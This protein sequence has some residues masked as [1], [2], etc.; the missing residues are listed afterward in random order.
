MQAPPTVAYVDDPP[1][2][3]GVLKK[4]FPGIMVLADPRHL[5]ARYGDVVPAGHGKKGKC[6]S[7]WC[8]R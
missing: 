8:D 2:F 5:M 3:E 6:E 7:V 4:H 1:Q